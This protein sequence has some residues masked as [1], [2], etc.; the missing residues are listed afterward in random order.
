MQVESLMILNALMNYLA[1]SWSLLGIA[2]RLKRFINQADL[3]SLLLG[4]VSN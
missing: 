1:W 4:L 3:E 2:Q